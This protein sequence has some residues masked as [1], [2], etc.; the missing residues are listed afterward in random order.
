MIVY[1]VKNYDDVYYFD[2]ETHGTFISKELA[3]EFMNSLDREHV[4]EPYIDELEVLE[5]LEKEQ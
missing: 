3:T 1:Q 4:K 2:I 5:S